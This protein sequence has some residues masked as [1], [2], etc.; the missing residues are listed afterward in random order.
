MPGAGPAVRVALAASAVQPSFA[1]CGER[2][3]QFGDEPV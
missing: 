1:G 2:F 3:G